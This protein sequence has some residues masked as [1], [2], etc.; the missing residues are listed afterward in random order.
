MFV[1]SYLVHSLAVVLACN[2]VC[3]APMFFNYHRKYNK[4][5]RYNLWRFTPSNV[6]LHAYG[7][8]IYIYIRD[9]ARYELF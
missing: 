3:I 7:V 5:H 9:T 2:V 8:T 1:L 6:G 4:V